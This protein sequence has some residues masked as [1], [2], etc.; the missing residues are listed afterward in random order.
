MKNKV[1]LLFV[2]IALLCSCSE[3]VL[4]ES[5]GQA[6]PSATDTAFSFDAI[7]EPSNWA[8]YQSLE[9]MLAAC[10]DARILQRH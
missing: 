7:T 4:K 6:A 1:Y 5:M 3:D 2:L 10:Q 9:E 8:Q